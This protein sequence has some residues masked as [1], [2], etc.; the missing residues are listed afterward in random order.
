MSCTPLTTTNTASPRMRYGL[1]ASASMARMIALVV[2]GWSRAA[3]EVSR[4]LLLDLTGNRTQ[5]WSSLKAAGCCWMAAAAP[6][7]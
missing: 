6:G 4:L 5:S 3:V 7:H 1:R 2:I